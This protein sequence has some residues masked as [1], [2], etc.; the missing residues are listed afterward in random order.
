MRAK[1]NKRVVSPKVELTERDMQLF[2]AV[3]SH[4]LMTR[5][6]IQD[7]FGWSCIS[8]VNR[9]LRK[10]FDAKYLD[11]RFLP[12]KFGQTPAVY[13]M[14]NEGLNILTENKTVQPLSLIHI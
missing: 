2:F 7:Y 14:G 8:D 13:F 1:P 11:R 5:T 12:R 10:L 9:R 3:Y 4:G 6:N